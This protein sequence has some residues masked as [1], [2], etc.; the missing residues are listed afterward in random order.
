MR[1]P[2]FSPRPLPGMPIA[3][4]LTACL[5]SAASL[6]RAQPPE[7][8]AADPRTLVRVN[9]S[10]VTQG[11]FE[12]A[13]LIHK[14]PPEQQ[15][16]AREQILN[17]LV[18]QQLMRQFLKTRKVQASPE[19]IDARLA[20]IRLMIER[21]GRDPEEVL[22]KVGVTEE[23]LR[24]SLELPLAWQQHMRQVITD[25]QIEEHFQTHRRRFDGTRLHVRQIAIPLPPDAPESL[26]ANALKTME[27]VRHEIVEEGKPFAA[28]AREHSR[29]PSAPQGGDMGWIAY[30]GRAARE[31]AEVVFTLQPQEVSSP[32]QTRF[33]VHLAT[34]EEVQPGE[35]SLEDARPEVFAE[36][37]RQ[38]WDEQLAQLRETASIEW[39]DKP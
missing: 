5:L 20:T 32:F 18:D 38:K 12:S 6:S 39:A 30:G 19:E 34:V 13:C 37:S 9:G 35:L 2:R 29:A 17:D 10:P 26:W 25:Q 8:R 33:G 15:G 22:Q 27:A 7:A 3:V 31:I 4:C 14:I 28:A 1:P 24:R 16:A 36:L 23:M 11:D 21:S